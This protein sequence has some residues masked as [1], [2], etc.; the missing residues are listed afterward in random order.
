MGVALHANLTTVDLGD[1]L[2]TKILEVV[3]SSE[4][5]TNRKLNA[6]LRAGEIGKVLGAFTDD[7]HTVALTPSETPSQARK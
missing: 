6:L 7:C 3:K 2:L 5:P 1:E 4:L